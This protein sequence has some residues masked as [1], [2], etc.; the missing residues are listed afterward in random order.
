VEK[1]ESCRPKY[2]IIHVCQIFFFLAYRQKSQTCEKM[3]FSIFDEHPN[4]SWSFNSCGDSFAGE[5]N[6]WK[7]GIRWQ[8]MKVVPSAK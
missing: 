2:P 8:A 5:W 3:G 6:L 1:L 4:D 7:A